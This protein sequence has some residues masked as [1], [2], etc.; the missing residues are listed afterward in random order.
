M[1]PQAVA[2]RDSAA[3]LAEAREAEVTRLLEVVADLRRNVSALQSRLVSRT[4]V[5]L[6]PCVS[7]LFLFGPLLCNLALVS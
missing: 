6:S 3:A 4:P 5:V 2:S 1:S 7:V